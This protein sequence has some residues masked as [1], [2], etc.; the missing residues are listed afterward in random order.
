MKKFSFYFLFLS[1]LGL[2]AQTNNESLD[3]IL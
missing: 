3:L 2:N 1:S